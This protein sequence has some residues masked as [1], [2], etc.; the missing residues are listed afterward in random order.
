MPRRSAAST[1]TSLAIIG[2]NG[3]ET[4]HRPD[5]P[6]DLDEEQ[7]RVWRDVVNRMPADWF[8][9]ETHGLLTQYCRLITRARRIAEF[10]HAMETM[11]KRKS[12]DF[13]LGTYRRLIRDEA[14]ISTAIAVL[15][16]NMRMSQAST[17]RQ[18]YVKKRPMIMKKPWDRDEETDEEDQAE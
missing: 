17:S 10:L 8:P 15:A 2:G 14:A 6:P 18:E 9:A 5:V 13:D 1:F 16:R 4:I 3:L 12:K 7:G 11:G